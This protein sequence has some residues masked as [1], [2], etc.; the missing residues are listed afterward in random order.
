MNY[1]Q[2]VKSLASSN[3]IFSKVKSTLEDKG[4]VVKSYNDLFIVYH[5]KEPNT[6]KPLEL[7]KRGQKSSFLEDRS[8]LRTSS[9]LEL[10]ELTKECRGLIAK[11]QDPTKIVCYGFDNF[12]EHPTDINLTE[13]KDPFRVI[14]SLDGTLLKLY[15]HNDQWNVATNRCISAKTARWNS[16]RSF[17]DM[18]L[19]ASQSMESLLDH[20]KLDKRCCYMMLLAHPEN[21]IVTPYE[22]PILYHIGT[23]NLNTLEELDIFLPENNIGMPQP[24]IQHF[25]SLEKVFEILDV[26][27][28]S[29]QGYVIELYKNDYTNIKRV[30]LIGKQ[31][32]HVHKVRGSE[33]NMLL[34]Y[35]TLRFNA[36]HSENDDDKQKL[37]EFAKYF[38][39]WCGVNWQIE[40]LAKW[41]H[42]QYMNIYVHKQPVLPQ[43]LNGQYWTVLRNIHSQY[44]T[45]KQPTKIQTIKKILDDNSPRFMCSLLS[46]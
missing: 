14:E 44:L 32:L 3:D 28:W 34:H 36:N 42:T 25:D 9:F 12:L 39:E 40:T 4:F 21:R 10:C 38:P 6:E 7:L 20:D 29:L 45:T 22:F 19:D 1:L 17:Y 11:I 18:Y 43:S 41:F 16:H 30:K 27:E 37:D 35:L 46:N 15:Y 2:L 8:E 5:P 31:H 23:R 24:S 33:Q 26:L 13:Y